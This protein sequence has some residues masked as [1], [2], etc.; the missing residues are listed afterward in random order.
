MKGKKL[1]SEFS[2]LKLSSN[3]ILFALKLAGNE[4]SI[5]LRC[6]ETS[7]KGGRFKL[8]FFKK[9]KQIL[10]SNITEEKEEKLTQGPRP[11]LGRVAGDLSKTKLKPWQIATFKLKF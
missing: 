5:I 9:P 3:L 10:I 6:Y 4:K 7:G 11:K 1:P 2:F 8:E